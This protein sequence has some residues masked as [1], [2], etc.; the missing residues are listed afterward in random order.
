MS[1]RGEDGQAPFS[2]FFDFP[3]RY[4]R[5]LLH[6]NKKNDTVK[7]RHPEGALGPNTM[8]S[9][10]CIKKLR[11][12]SGRGRRQKGH[13]R[14]HALEPAKEI[15]TDLALVFFSLFVLETFKK[16]TKALRHFSHMLF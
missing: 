9:Y 11:L 14:G 4:F 7:K 5:Q 15:G 12:A 10:L 2:C 16:K 13:Q 8:A 1:L 6:E 3:F